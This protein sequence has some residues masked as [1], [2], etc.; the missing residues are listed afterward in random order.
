MTT[1]LSLVLPQHPDKPSRCDLHDCEHSASVCYAD[2]CENESWDLLF[3]NGQVFRCHDGDFQPD[4]LEL[5]LPAPVAVSWNGRHGCYVLR[6]IGWGAM[7]HKGRWI[8]VVQRMIA[9]DAADFE[10]QRV[11]HAQLLGEDSFAHNL[12]ATGRTALAYLFAR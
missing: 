7:G 5:D 11:L 10:A 3:V 4:P 6:E 2:D 1:V 9:V 12:E 8:N